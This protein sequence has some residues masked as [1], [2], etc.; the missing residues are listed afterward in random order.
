MLSLSLFHSLLPPFASKGENL[1]GMG[2][3]KIWDF[4]GGFIWFSAFIL[5]DRFAFLF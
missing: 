5:Q 2:C 4:G 1:F 3:Q